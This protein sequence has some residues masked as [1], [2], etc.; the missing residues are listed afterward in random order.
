MDIYALNNW[1]ATIYAYG[2]NLVNTIFGSSIWK[3]LVVILT[4]FAV[5]KTLPETLDSPNIPKQFL[6]RTAAIFAFSALTL[7]P[8]T[9]PINVY[10]ITKSETYTNAFKW[11]LPV[12][13]KDKFEAEL[14]LSAEAQV[15]V[16][17]ALTGKVVGFF[18]FWAMWVIDKSGRTLGTDTV[19]SGLMY[20]AKLTT[21]QREISGGLDEVVATLQEKGDW[22]PED[23]RRYSRMQNVLRDFFSKDCVSPD[24]VDAAW[25]EVV[26]GNSETTSI[27]YF[28]DHLNRNLSE[29][30]LE[31][32]R[33]LGE[34]VRDTIKNF[35]ERWSSA[36]ED[37]PEV[38]NSMVEISFWKKTKNFFNSV[39]QGIKEFPS[40][41]LDMLI[42]FVTSF[43][44]SLF[45]AAA[46]VV[47]FIFLM[48]MTTIAPVSLGVINLLIFFLSPLF[49]LTQLVQRNFISATVR[50]ILEMLWA[51]LLYAVF[52]LAYV[53]VCVLQGPAWKVLLGTF[54]MSGSLLSSSTAAKVLA[55]KLSAAVLKAGG[56]GLL[57]L[58]FTYTAITLAAGMAVMW[59]GVQ[60]LR[61][62]IFG[63]PLHITQI[64]TSGKDFMAK[65]LRFKGA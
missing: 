49:F 52:V 35:C 38:C 58:L 63:E 64:L 46:G 4:V 11:I 44:A 47:N 16:V 23:Q 50:I 22:T 60:V 30:K 54:G 42:S 8:V 34:Y 14:Y 29:S 45:V 20:T 24:T 27:D 13:R 33:E 57:S 26:N 5:F 56:M 25:N 43:L 7:W 51:R 31:E 55:K 2:I 10:T 36:T 53:I 15:P 48:G 6:K 12:G 61:T 19:S 1:D 9:W 18:Q 21:L 39:V 32:C 59:F 3:A 17:V 40:R 62:I 37:P 28:L 65:R 41:V